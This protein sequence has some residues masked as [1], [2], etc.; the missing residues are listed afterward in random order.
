M[1]VSS[2]ASPLTRRERWAK[3]LFWSW[4]MIFLAFM[5]LGFAP[6]VLPEMITAIRL[7]SIDGMFLLYAI[8][9]TSIPLVATMLGFT[10][11]RGQPGKLFALGYVVEGPLMLILGVRF[12]AVR[13]ASTGLSFLII[14]AGLGLAAF[15]WNLLD[16]RIEQRGTSAQWLRLFGL[17]LMALVSLYAAL[18]IAFY[19]IPLLAEALKWL[20]DA[21]L[22]LSRVFRDLWQSLRSLFGAELLWLPYILLGTVLALYTAT[23]VVLAPIAVPLLSL[24]AWRAAL[25]SLSTRSGK[26]I[27]A[28]GSLLFAAAAVA[29]FALANQQPQGRIFSML[30]KPPQS[31]DQARRLIA[32]G[33]K[34]RSGL[35]NAY[36]G[37][38]RYFSSVGEVRHIASIYADVFN[39]PLDQAYQV[40]RVYEI[41]ARPMLY[42]PYQ[43][44]D[45]AVIN[46]DWQDMALRREPLRAARLYQ[47][48]FDETIVEGERPEILRAVRSTWSA[49]QA[50]AAL[51]ALQER[52]VHL[53]QQEITI[54]EHG[55]WAEIE[56][57]EVYRNTTAE[58]QE[59]IYYFSL[60]ESAVITG[61][62]LGTSA[63]RASRFE[64]IV[65]PRGAA[66]A[67]YRN[68]VRRNIDPALVEQIGPRQ[69]RLRAF[70]IPEVIT[71]FDSET[72]RST[73]GE[74]PQMHLWLS[75]KTLAEGDSWPMPRLT[76]ERDIYW[77]AA[78]VRMVNG[79]V[80]EAQD[81]NAW[82]PETL[83]ASG[84]ITP[85][86]H[87]ALLPG[88][89]QVTIQ[90]ADPFDLPSLAADARLAVVLDRSRSMQALSVE[91]EQALGW[92]RA[93][94]GAQIDLYLTASNFRGESPHRI[95][96][97]DLQAGPIEYLGGQNPAE[98]LVQFDRLR[99]EQAYDA[100]IVLTDGSGYELG[101]SYSE[102]R[103]PDFPVWLVHLGD[104]I[105][106][107]Y[108][109][110]TLAALQGSRGGVSGSLEEALQRIA[111]GMGAAN[112]A[113]AGAL[114]T[115]DVLDGYLWQTGP[116]Q[117]A[118][119]DEPAFA[120][121][122]ARRV[123]LAEMQRQ[124]GQ[125][126][127]PATLDRLN[128]LAVEQRIVTPY[129]SMIV[130]VNL[131]Q[132]ELLEDLSKLEDRYQREVEGLGETTPATNLPLSGVPEP[133][134]WLLI[135]LALAL[136]GYVLLT[137]RGH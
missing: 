97:G 14:A 73:I 6:R 28:L 75:W 15:L 51:E 78:T 41:V 12:F 108:D 62:W 121:L 133:E 116:A 1:N 134:E 89:Y 22:H 125:L 26:I 36:L 20:W 92:L 58:R 64:P 120:P 111:A 10:L 71:H 106:I 135:G 52:E 104:Q 32:E 91:A 63:D 137:R 109:D 24:R 96:L 105:P 132:K 87:Q 136:A 29:L 31:V 65:A 70:P 66:Q 79:A 27:P 59:V 77:D 93:A 2:V 43:P 48:V 40:E 35:L 117:S 118:T 44:T 131:E 128:A 3:G 127:D 30:E 60:P 21:L 98:L 102:L 82:L 53:D 55:D 84:P 85:Q 67:V 123:I 119:V 112:R 19:A 45:P 88:G 13:Q 8:I 47:R 38:F 99:G 54:H 113:E 42:Q 83:P 69:Y 46:R 114:I 76:L 100:A 130:L 23:L 124:R 74:A 33:E 94:G 5:S 17:T 126:D 57:H 80:V 95:A 129:S 39:L 81:V 4:N 50:E 103:V 90:P 16:R 68:E 37:P 61:V 11:L 107:G 56:L 101:E 7:D 25:R 18:W 9:L 122:A 72:S 86:T 115:Q 34:L 49:G 110:Q